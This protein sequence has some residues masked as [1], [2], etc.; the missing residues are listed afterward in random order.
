MNVLFET[1]VE[2]GFDFAYEELTRDVIRET[3]RSEHF[4]ENV[5][6]SLLLTDAKAVHE[7]N[8]DYRGIDSTT[9][10]L[11]F[12]LIDFSTPAV[13][14]DEA[15]PGLTDPDTGNYLLGDIVLNYERVLS[16]AKEYGHS[17]RREYA[18]LIAHSMLHLLGYDHM[19]EGEMKKQMRCREEEIAKTVGGVHR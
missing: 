4:P 7:M 8:R 2:V 19:D 15:D 13:L 5:E 6:V 11:S 12:P 17:V 3:L 9:D 10:V 18:F 16:Q 1:E 14:S